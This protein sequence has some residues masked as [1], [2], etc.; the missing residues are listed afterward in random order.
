MRTLVRYPRPANRVP[1]GPRGFTLLEV[2]VVLLIVGLLVSLVAPSAVNLMGSA[3]R[4]AQR[5]EIASAIER[6]P[7]EAWLAGKPLSFEGK[8]LL[9]GLN[10]AWRVTLA[11]PL[12]VL[13]S[14]VCTDSDATIN[15]DDQTVVVHIAA[16]FCRVRFE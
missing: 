2:L 9:P 5:R 8:T 12:R 15:T 7:V 16:P 11:K 3:T 10:A 13:P 14:G 6:L 4:E 1:P